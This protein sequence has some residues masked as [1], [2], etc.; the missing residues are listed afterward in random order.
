MRINVLPQWAAVKLSKVDRS[1]AIKRLVERSYRRWT[2]YVERMRHVESLV[3]QIP[4]VCV[5]GKLGEL[6]SDS[7]ANFIT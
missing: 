6:G 3:V 4:H 2:R 7:N 5:V 1:A